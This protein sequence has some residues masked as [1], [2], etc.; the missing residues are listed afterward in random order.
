MFDDVI[1]RYLVELKALLSS[2]KLRFDE[3][4][5]GKL[6]LAPGV[7]R[8]FRTEEDWMT[9]MYVGRS[10]NLKDRIYY[11]L[12]M[13]D[14][15]AHTLKNKLI[16]SDV[17]REERDAKM[18]LKESCMCQYRV[19]EEKRERGLFEHFAIAVLKPEFND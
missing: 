19:I 15:G 13:G 9:T 18:Y 3:E 8:V 1:Q 17:C 4:L 11:N 2:E 7:Y 12:L 5:H 10:V 14:A 6:T 16:N